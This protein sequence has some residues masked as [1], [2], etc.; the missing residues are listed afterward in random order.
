LGAVPLPAAD[1]EADDEEEDDPAGNEDEIDDADDD[2]DEDDDVLVT[3]GT[4]IW[5]D[6]SSGSKASHEAR[7]PS[8]HVIVP[9][10][11]RATSTKSACS[12]PVWS[13]GPCVA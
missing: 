7:S 8:G 5:I 6:W 2:D 1:C 9:A 13:A 11:D 4:S 12:S 10:M 3:Y